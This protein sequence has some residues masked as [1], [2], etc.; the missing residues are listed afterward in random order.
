MR[1]KS[2]LAGLAVIGLAS[3]WL[4][5]PPA[6]QAKDDKVYEMTL[7]W[8]DIWGPKFRASQVYAPGGV[9]QR[10]LH[11]RSGGRIQLKI[12]S[13]MFPAT[14][15]LMAVA[16]GKADMGDIPMPWHS[17]TYPLWSWGE[18]PGI[19]SSDPV[20][21][22]AEELAVYQD[23]RV[24]KIYDESM[25]KLGLKFWFV[26]QWDPANGI[27]SK[28]E[29]KTLDDMKGLKIR[30]GGF[31]PTI[32]M[33]GMGASPVTISGSELAPAMM[34]GTI[35]A[36]LTSLGYGYS[37]GLA[38]AS[39]HFTLTPLSPTWTAVTVISKKKFESLPGDL[40]EI[41]LQVGREVQQM[42]SLSTTAEY[43]LSKDALALSGV[44]IG[45]LEP[46]EQKK[47]L[48]AAKPVEEEWL[49]ETGEEGKKLLGVIRDVTAKYR[50]FTG[51]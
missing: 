5:G 36:V 49:K 19:V 20:E 17:G 46:S 4:A 32:G 35:D 1:G 14:D 37:I 38:E 42:V 31:L 15:I 45:T 7:A 51:N 28:K 47:A 8:N 6:A 10:M 22:L 11:E 44:K 39:S 27:W 30:V 9:L 13:R 43:I 18:I 48:A 33:K 2:W 26:T 12:V 23:P 3:S 29:L 40:Q 50:A 25:G 34:A 21:G 24:V 16:R 41:V